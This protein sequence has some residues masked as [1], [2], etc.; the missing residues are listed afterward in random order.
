MDSSTLI[1][2]TGDEISFQK[3]TSGYNIGLGADLKPVKEPTSVIKSLTYK[4]ITSGFGLFGLDF[5]K[6]YF[7]VNQFEIKDRFL[8]AL[9]PLNAKFLNLITNKVDFY[10]PFWICALLVVVLSTSGHLAQALMHM[11]LNYGSENY[12]QTG[13]EYNFENIGFAVSLIFGSLVLFPGLFITVY[14]SFGIGISMST[15]V[16][17]YG[18]SFLPFVFAGIL[19]IYPDRSWRWGCMWLAC[20]HSVCFLITNFKKQIELIQED[21]KLASILG[22]A[23][24]QAFLT[25]TFGFKFYHH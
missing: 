24:A 23:G 14:K 17:V 7:D 4:N 20:I 19:C 12:Y 22:I 1:S 9:N 10:A 16:C 25:F 18:Y 2:V 8:A 15:A 3:D 6:I 21:W 5:W 13:N 11:M